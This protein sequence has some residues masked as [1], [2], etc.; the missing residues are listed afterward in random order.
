MADPWNGPGVEKHLLASLFDPAAAMKLHFKSI[1]GLTKWGMEFLYNSC[2]ARHRDAT[3][4]NYKLSRYS[5]TQTDEWRQAENIDCDWSN[6]GALKL[7]PSKEAMAGLL[8]IAEILRPHGMEID[9]LEKAQV[10]E[11]EPR[12]KDVEDKLECA[13]FYSIDHT[14]DCRK[15]AVG[16]SEAMK[17]SAA[18]IKS[19]VTVDYAAL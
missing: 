13:I 6:S 11:R 5:L 9:I 12:L 15:F 14:A 10:L 7:F 19:G 16:L 4:A 1:P 8:K 3:I 2:A 18:E 17:D